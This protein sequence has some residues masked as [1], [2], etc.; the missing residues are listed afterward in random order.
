LIWEA[1]GKIEE[2]IDEF[3]S[4]TKIYPEME[5][6]KENLVRALRKKQAA[7]PKEADTFRPKEATDF[8]E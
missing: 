5:D 2:A 1:Q 4:A 3:H 7:P 6:M 8:K